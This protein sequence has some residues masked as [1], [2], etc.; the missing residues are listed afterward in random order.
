M[1]GGR[2]LVFG[3]GFS[4]EFHFFADDLLVDI[5]GDFVEVGHFGDFDLFGFWLLLLFCLK[6]ESKMCF[7]IDNTFRTFQLN[8]LFFFKSL[9]N[10]DVYE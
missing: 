7:M 1:D 9:S 6:I 10:Y 3:G 8:A 4:G 2:R 5:A